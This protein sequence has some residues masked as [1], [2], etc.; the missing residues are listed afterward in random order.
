M[1]TTHCRLKSPKMGTHDTKC[2]ATGAG[3]AHQ[4]IGSSESKRGPQWTPSS[5][6][7]DRQDIIIKIK[8]KE[9]HEH[10]QGFMTKGETDETGEMEKVTR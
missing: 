7:C 3:Q 2:S 9:K 1:D 8:V 6:S 5:D 10:G 4:K